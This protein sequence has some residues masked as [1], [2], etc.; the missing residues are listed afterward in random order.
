[1]TPKELPKEVQN[2]AIPATPATPRTPRFV[3]KW[4]KLASLLF[5]SG[6]IAIRNDY[7]VILFWQTIQNILGSHMFC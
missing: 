1:M 6:T 2:D 5:G 7:R 4:C 3:W